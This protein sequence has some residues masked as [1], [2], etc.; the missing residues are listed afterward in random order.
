M[1]SLWSDPQFYIV[2]AAALW[3]LW[4]LARPFLPSKKGSSQACPSCSSGCAP[5]A[6]DPKGAA[7]GST[8]SKPLVS[9]GRSP[10]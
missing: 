10:G 8:K 9:L 3:G 7:S 6:N 2:T 5:L 4:T 1:E